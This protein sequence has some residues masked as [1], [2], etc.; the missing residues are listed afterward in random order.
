[1]QRGPDVNTMANAAVYEVLLSHGRTI[2][3]G[4][5]F[6]PDVLKRLIT[7]VEASC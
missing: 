5:N 2:R 6:D 7:T 1:M 3:V 4:H